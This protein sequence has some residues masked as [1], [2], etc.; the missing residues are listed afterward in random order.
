MRIGDIATVSRGASPRPISSP[1]WFSAT[2]TVGWVRI[3]D[4][5]RSD[6]L[7]LTATT[8]RL[9]ADGISRSRLLPPGTLIMSIA[10]TVGLP[11]ITAIPTCIHDGFVALERLEGVDQTY[12]LYALKSLTVEIRGAGQTGS[13]SNVNTEIV[14]RLAVIL[15]PEPEQKRVVE[16]LRDFDRTIAA[17][18]RLIAKKE[19]IKRGM[20]QGIFTHREVG[21]AAKSLGRVTSSWLSGGT[22]NRA[23]VEYWSGTIPWISASTLKALEVSSSGQNVTSLAV[24]AGSKMAPLHSTLILVR[25]SALHSEIRA[26]LVT[27]PLCFNQDVKAL[28]PSPELVPKFL[29][30]SLHGNAVRLLQR[31]TSAGNTAGVLDTGVLRRF[32]IWVP[33]RSEQE[34]VVAMLDDV[35][36]N[37]AVLRRRLVQTKAIKQGMMQELLTGR[38]RLPVAEEVLL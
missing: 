13:Q 16:A 37:T 36:E 2:S 31:V 23:N 14:K 4:L 7:A 10:A 17:L 1:R 6:G 12:L 32:E 22:P 21:S 24:K 8:Q 30:Y 34:K 28:V 35:E 11:I 19:A 26:A 20:M 29:T 25:G 38:T 3:A 18:E 15:P 33:D 9:S 5:A 27:A